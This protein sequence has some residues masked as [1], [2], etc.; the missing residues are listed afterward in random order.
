MIKRVRNTKVGDI[1]AAKIDDKHKKYLQYIISDMSQLN[2]DVIRAFSKTYPLE[3]NPSLEDIIKDK[4]DFYAHCSTKA[5]IKKS[6]W[7]KV[8]NISNVG[9]IDHILFRD[10]GDFGN[11]Q[12]KISDDWWVWK[13]NEPFMYVGK[14]EG[15]YKNAEIGVV[16]QPERI[17]NKLKTGSYL[18]AYPEFR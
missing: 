10:S 6:L 5:G 9:Q 4:V 17:I 15:E 13:I 11:P 12:V 1:F 3:A 14:L 16:F 2:S 18:I 8:G 7:E